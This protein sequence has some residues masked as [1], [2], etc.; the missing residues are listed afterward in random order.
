MT[1]LPPLSHV[2]VPEPVN[3]TRVLCKTKEQKARRFAWV[4]L[5]FAVFKAQ[6]FSA[7]L[8]KFQNIKTFL[9]LEHN[10]VNA[11]TV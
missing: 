11:F 5:S 7:H 6:F 8:K 2:T 4:L 10:I 3:N 9:P 1:A